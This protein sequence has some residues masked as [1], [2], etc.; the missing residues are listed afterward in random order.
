MMPAFQRSK[1][2]V[3]GFAFVQPDEDAAAFR[4]RAEIDVSVVIDVGGD[5]RHDAIVGFQNLRKAARY[6]HH[7][8]G[9]GWPRQHDAVGNTITVEIR[10][11]CRSRRYEQTRA[12]RD[13]YSTTSETSE[14]DRDCS[15]WF[16]RNLTSAIVFANLGRF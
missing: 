9:V 3:R 1:V 16:S 4:K 13:E 11:D 7:D 14:R 2:T 15:Q 10:L 6:P 12:G 5:D 8:V